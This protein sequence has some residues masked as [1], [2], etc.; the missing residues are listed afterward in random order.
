MIKL[1]MVPTFL[2][3]QMQWPVWRSAGVKL[4][5][6]TTAVAAVVL[7]SGCA[8]QTTEQAAAAAANP[9]PAAET[10]VALDTPANSPATTPK[11]SARTTA[12]AVAASRQDISQL[13]ALGCSQTVECATMGVGARAC[14][15]PE[16]FLAYSL[17][18][19]PATALQAAV[20]R[21]ATLRK[22]QL[23]QR[24]EMSTCELLPDPG[25]LCSS[26]R[27]CQL[28]SPPP[29]VLNHLLR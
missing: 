2:A 14:G 4:V 22:K 28:A 16:A 24:G 18:D 21:H 27:R 23:E 7:A 26:A 19:T 17:R 20:R 10:A 5:C 11:T 29:G 1:P 3:T 13:L 6:R 12:D 15:G 25:A 9:A 8:Q